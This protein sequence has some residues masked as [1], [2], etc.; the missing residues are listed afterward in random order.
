MAATNKIACRLSIQSAFIL[1]PVVLTLA[2]LASVAY[3]LS[4]ESA[5]NA[6][7]V[8]REQ[9]QDT[10]LYVAQAGYN[11]AIWYLNRQNCTGYSDIPTHNLGNQN[12]LAAFT[13]TNGTTLT[14]GSPTNIKVVGTLANG[15]S[16]TL[17][18]NREKVYQNP[19][20]LVLQ[21]DAASGKDAYLWYPGTTN[22]YGSARET[23]VSTMSNDKTV[24]LYQFDL[25]AVPNGVKILSA[26]LSL[27][28]WQG[29][30]SNV[31]ISAHRITNS[32]NETRVSWDNRTSTQAW[33]TPAGDFDPEVI[34]TTLVGPIS[35]IRYEWQLRSVVEKWVSGSQPNYGV[36][37]RT[38]APKIDGERFYTSDDS[39]STRHPRLTITYA[40]ECG[41]VCSGAAVG[42]LLLVVVNPAS[43]TV[44]ETD[45]KALFE[46]WGYLVTLIDMDDTQSAFDTALASNDVVFITEDIDST[47]LNTK[48]VNATIGVV[49]EEDDLSDEFGMASTI[50][51]DSGDTL[52]ITDNSHY[53]TQPFSLGNLT[54]MTAVNSLAYV[55]G[56]RSV[57]LKNLGSIISRPALVALDVG[58]TTYTAG[59]AVGRRVQLPWGGNTFDVNTLNADGLTLLQRALEWGAEVVTSPPLSTG[60]NGTF[61]DEFND[62]VYSGNNGIFNWLGD[63][64][65]IN[66]T[67]GP[68]KG[69][70]QVF[71]DLYEVPAMPTNQLHVRDNDSGGEGVMRALDLSNATTATLSFDYKPAGLDNSNDYASVQMSSTGVAGPWTEVVRFAG[72]ANETAYQ[73]FSTDISSYLSADTVLRIITSPNMGPKDYLFLDNIQIECSK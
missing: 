68:T 4:R 11:H 9:Q 10:A 16:Y 34:D 40:C 17:L 3:L 45:K 61:R 1:L 35:K 8:N 56:T 12:Y 18:R 55:S 22:N 32:W 25:G 48:L 54:V 2:I 49:T 59:T 58:A 15:T 21:P 50:T 23:W 13:D 60:C 27:L 37:L 57:D 31:P 7:N 63:W 24:A 5:I 6:G 73:F 62:I 33:N 42:N 65:E 64:Q 14:A 46:S 70:E 30:D 36:L 72:P 41:V 43:L 39:N 71:A 51:W 28:H 26:T 52:N 44:Q 66:E 29:W 20:T 38:I 69:D 19:I 67:N 47:R 53:I